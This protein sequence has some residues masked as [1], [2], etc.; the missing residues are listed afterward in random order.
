MEVRQLRYFVTVARTR[1]FGRAAE[2][3]HIAQSPLSQ[4]IRQLESHLGTPLFERTTRRVDL[5]PAGEA[6]LPEAVRIL[7]SVGAAR[8]QVS[9]VAAGDLGRLRIG[10]TALATYRHVPELVRR[11]GEELPDL[12]LRFRTEMLTPALEAALTDHRID[13]AV[14][15]PPVGDDAIATRVLARERLV[16]AVPAAWEGPSGGSV[17]AVALGDLADEEFV[18]YSAPG[19]VVGAAADRACRGA[20]FVPRRTHEADQTSIVL[21]LV[22]AGLGVALLPASVLAVTVDGVHYR[23][24][25]GCDVT[26]DVALAWRHEDPSPALEKALA[27]LGRVE[28]PPEMKNGPQ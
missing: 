4:A 26:A 23:E 21:A 8:E 22:A 27:V 3:L 12:A 18:V 2:Q 1:H 20:G 17:G 13:L 11:L 14:L 7:E 6:L 16:L 9:R 15:R 25:T 28:T 24:L 5:T 19:S 10:S